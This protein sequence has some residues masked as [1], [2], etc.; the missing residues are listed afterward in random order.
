MGTA[1]YDSIGGAYHLV[2]GLNAYHRTFWGVSTAAYRDFASQAQAACAAGRLLDAG[3]GSLL[4]TSHLHATVG[5]DLSGKM[6][7]RA[8]RRAVNGLGLVQADLLRIPFC[9]RSFDGIVCL[10]V[11]HVI[12]DLAGLLRELRRILKPGGRLF[13]TSAVLT[14]QWRDRYLR[15]LSRR[16]ILA[17]PRTAEEV[18]GAIRQAFG[19]QPKH[20][21]AGSMLF[22]DTS[23]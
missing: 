20:Y 2:A 13:L 9:D 3:C 21:L 14:G 23:S 22:T 19:V 17:S 16:G 1:Q 18:I 15:L 7:K 10:H 8:R 6:L 12:E 4:F 11:T 5:T